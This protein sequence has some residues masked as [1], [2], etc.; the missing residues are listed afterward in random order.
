MTTADPSDALVM[1]APTF[2]TQ[3]SLAM[4]SHLKRQSLKPSQLP[5]VSDIVIPCEKRTRYAIIIS[6]YEVYNDRIYDLLDET[7]FSNP[8]A[9]HKSLIFRTLNAHTEKKVVAG[10]RK[11]Y[12]RTYEEALRLL[13]HGLACRH[14]SATGSNE[15]S[16]RSH[17]FFA[18]EVKRWAG[19]TGQLLPSGTFT[20]VDLAGSERVRQAKTQGDRLVEAGSINRSLM[21]LGQCL[22]LQTQS[23][24]GKVKKAHTH[25][26]VIEQ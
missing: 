7:C 12:V 5:D 8:S 14:S 19:K 13:D 15:T 20:V 3:A 9:R 1:S 18:I 26:P 11:I 25:T 10:L 16:S 6:M 4:D 21:S 24:N 2:F 23:E 22:Q 17:A